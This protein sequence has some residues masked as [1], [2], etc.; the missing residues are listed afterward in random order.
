MNK[1]KLKWMIEYFQRT[2]EH[3]AVISPSRKIIHS[4]VPEWFK[5]KGGKYSHTHRKGAKGGSEREKETHRE[6]ERK[7]LKTLKQM[8]HWCKIR[9]INN[10]WKPRD[11]ENFLNELKEKFF[12]TRKRW[13]MQDKRSKERERKICDV[14]FDDPPQTCTLYTVLQT[15]R[16]FYGFKQII[17]NILHQFGPFSVF[18]AYSKFFFSKYIFFVKF[19]VLTDFKRCSTVRTYGRR[20]FLKGCIPE[21]LH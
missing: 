8:D 19:S 11:H 13:R 6:R 3:Y 16:I 15:K 20:T 1:P 5:P 2:D 14:H 7:G 18:W 10:V 21:M 17:S 4:D 12:W 9:W